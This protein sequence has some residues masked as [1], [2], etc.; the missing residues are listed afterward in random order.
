MD[1]I[2]IAIIVVY[3]VLT[4]LIAKHIGAKRKIGYGKSVFWSLA[5]TPIIGLII[6]KMSKE[7]DIQ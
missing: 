3:I 6:A 2:W 5:F 7:I 1:N 4:H